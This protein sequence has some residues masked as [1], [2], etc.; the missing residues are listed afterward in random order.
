MYK[1][2]QEAFANINR[3][4][5]ELGRDLRQSARSLRKKPGLVIVS[6]LSLGLGI[7]VNTLLYMGISKI[8]G[9]QPT[10]EDPKRVVGV[11]LGNG[12]QFSYPD[13][14]DLLQTGIFA[15]AVGFRATALNYGP[16]EGLKRIP[17]TV[18]TGNYFKVLGISAA[19][20]RA[21]APAEVLPETEPRVVVVTSGFWRD[22]LG[23]DPAAIGKPLLLNGESFTVAGVL[24]DNYQA[25]T[26]WR[27]RGIY[28]PLSKF[29]LPSMDDRESTSLTVLGR[30]SPGQ[31]MESAQQAIT[32]FNA[33]LERAF[34]NRL[35][36]REAAVFPAQELQFRG[37]PAQLLLMNIA[38]GAAIAV[39]LIACVNVAGLLL[40]RAT[41]R[42]GEMAIRGALGAGRMRIAQTMLVESFVLVVSGA[43]VGIPLASVLNRV[44][45]PASMAPLQDA[46]TLDS[47]IFPYAAL[48]IG[49]ATLVCGLMPTIRLM[50]MNLN[51]ELS[52]GG[53]LNMTPRIWL[54][55][56]LVAGQV[57]MT[58]VLI[59]AALLCVRSQFRIA[60][61]DLGFELD[62][63]VVAQ[64]ALAPNQYP[65]QDRVRFADRLTKRI[66]QIPGV[67]SVSAADLVPLG[68]NGLIKSF[69][70]AGR[71]DIRGTRPDTYSVGPEYF[72]TLGVS[73]LRGREFNEFDRA[74]SRPVVIVNETFARTYFSRVDVIEESVQ[75][76]DQADARII[77]VVRDSRI[78]TIGERPKSVV[79]YPFAQRP[80]DLRIHVRCAMPPATMVA[81][82]QQAIKE[83]DG[84][85]PVSVQTL[86]NA[87]NLELTMRRVGIVLMGVLG[88]VGLMLAAAGLY[89]V[90]SYVAAARTPD[91]A[92]RMALGA[93]RNRIRWDMLRRTLIVVVPSV[94]IGAFLSLVIMPA[95]GTFLAGV[96]PFD[97][98]AYGST[99]A[100]FVLTGLAA[101]YIPAQRNARLDPMQV[102]RRQ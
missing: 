90:M 36:D 63:S 37:A 81:S 46:M 1:G 61:L 47:R 15:D 27:D 59:V 92:V 11:E 75:T 12:N 85:I 49:V 73:L 60:H 18:V 84:T 52:Q 96:S 89:G 24:P 66:E 51:A 29:I 80:T 82:V 9:H 54:R 28:V 17:A 102:L 68:G 88:A 64:F 41:D 34:P 3:R 79:Y 50:R 93:S 62:H 86:H 55:E 8:Y 99:A 67:V 14:K 69:H 77:G 26:G 40:A 76:A 91:V 83:I 65:G 10:M 45:M 35:K 21:F 7:G 72:H 100:I 53:R 78:D 43:A 5:E 98:V 13:Y 97:A 2:F 33:R 6:A 101:G 71:T 39:L 22:Y 56:M 87:T 16:K 32:T 44:P 23:S 20:G 70:P 95:L 48:L 94:I 19:L 31:S 74:G 4:L 58:F 30:M 57:A 25:M 42:R 38:W